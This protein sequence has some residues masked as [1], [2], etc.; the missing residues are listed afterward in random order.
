[1]TRP[2]L[3][4]RGDNMN[5]HEQILDIL[6]KTHGPEIDAMHVDEFRELCDLD[7]IVCQIV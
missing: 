5:K 6:R 1:M 4:L 7:Y 3:K 2:L